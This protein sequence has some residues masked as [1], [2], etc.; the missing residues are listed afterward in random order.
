[1]CVC[2]SP[3]IC[4]IMCLFVC[5]CVGGLAVDEREAC[6]FQH[7]ELFRVAYAGAL[8]RVGDTQTHGPQGG[9]PDLLI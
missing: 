3:S 2:V 4:G 1:M 7:D 9:G 6:Y 5:V 8:G